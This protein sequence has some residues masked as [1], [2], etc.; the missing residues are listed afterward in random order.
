[1]GKWLELDQTAYKNLGTYF[2]HLFYMLLYVT[3]T[4]YVCVFS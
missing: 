4:I 3:K 1:M 2:L